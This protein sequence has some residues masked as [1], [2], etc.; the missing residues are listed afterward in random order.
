MNR[1]LEDEM[2]A[3]QT[4]PAPCPFTLP[5]AQQPPLRLPRDQLQTMSMGLSAGR[6][7]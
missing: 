1:T 6:E 3:H 5:P 7:G 4:A 2:D